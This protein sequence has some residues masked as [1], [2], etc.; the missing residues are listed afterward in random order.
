MDPANTDNTLYHAY[1]FKSPGMRRW[2]RF[3]AH[4]WGVDKMNSII[5]EDLKEDVKMKLLETREKA[6]QMK[7]NAKEKVADK[8]EKIM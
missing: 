6:K 5:K 4:N 3:K 1:L 7:L 2:I 8:K